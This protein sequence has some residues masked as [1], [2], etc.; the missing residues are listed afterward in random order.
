M[1][2]VASLVSFYFPPAVLLSS[3]QQQL[4][5]SPSHLQVN[6]VFLHTGSYLEGQ[7]NAL[8]AFGYSRD[9]KKGKQQIVI[10]LLCDEAGEAVSTEMFHGNTQ[11]VAAFGAQVQKAARRFGCERV[12]VVGDGGMIKSG[13]IEELSRAGFYYITAVTKAEIMRLLHTLGMSLPE[14][15]PRTK[16]RVDTRKKLPPRRKYP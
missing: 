16:A 5:R 1:L 15:L 8:G 12:T 13:G 14:A 10:G 3:L 4:I 7:K 6:P 9:G 11:D 2:L